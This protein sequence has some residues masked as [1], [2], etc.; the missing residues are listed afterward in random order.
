MSLFH[1]RDRARM[2][3]GVMTAVPPELTLVRS[4]ANQAAMLGARVER[5]IAN[6]LA[7]ERQENTG[8][9]RDGNPGS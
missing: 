7:Y 4:L 5:E 3:E 9:G 6:E 2:D 1:R 8:G